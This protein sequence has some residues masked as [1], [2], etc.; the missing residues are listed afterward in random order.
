MKP[1]FNRRGWTIG[2]LYNGVIF[3]RNNRC[4]AFVRDGYVFTYA[5]HYI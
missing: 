4:R 2:W 5:S 1:I 3:D